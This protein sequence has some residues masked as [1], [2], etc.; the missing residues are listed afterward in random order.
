MND[1]L[2]LRNVELEGRIRDVRLRD[3][4]VAEIGESLRGGTEFDGR[5]GALIPG[6]IDHHIHILATAA[7]AE[8]I[9]VQSARDAGDFARIVRDGLAARAE[10]RWARVIGYHERAAGDLDRDALDEIAP[11]HRLRVQHQTGSLWVL[12]G[13]AIDAVLTDDA[14]VERDA[15]GRATGR[16]W[17]GDDWLRSRLGDQPPPLAPL[18]LALAAY[19][20]TGL[21]DASVTN[22]ASSAALLSEAHRAGSL[23]QRLALMSGRALEADSCVDVGP[24]KILLDEH[25]LPDFEEAGLRIA[26]AR[27][28]G[29][30]VAVHCVTAGE[31]A[32]TL[33]AF[34]AHGVRPGDR[35]EHGGVI[36]K[37]SIAMIL[38]L[39]L[40]TVTQ[41]AFVHERGDRY[42]ADMPAPEHRDLYRCASLLAAGAKVAASSDAPYGSYDPW[43]AMRAARDRTTRS[44]APIATAE[45]V[46]AGTALD[47]FLGGFETPAAPRRITAG[48]RADLC[49]LKTPLR[50][51]LDT[52]ASDQ[53]AATIIGGKIA[54]QAP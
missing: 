42:L 1:G 13:P 4:R 7:K 9:D 8:S 23:P 28:W 47:L 45:R 38:R 36:P 22:N 24:V 37:E 33:A 43:L 2:L 41:P 12:N 53:V 35:I 16:I 30:H 26:E 50:A 46:P 40:T 6:L 54:Y 31:L 19:G 14:P 18:G 20:V 27:R 51:A 48:A 25:N 52:L 39:G 49:L 29:R 11:R 21:M 15:R 3:G 34:E 10:G 17:R 5:G 44:G 32:F